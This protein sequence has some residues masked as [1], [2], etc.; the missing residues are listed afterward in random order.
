V[1]KVGDRL[2]TRTRGLTIALALLVPGIAILCL[3]ILQ[4]V[5]RAS[6]NPACVEGTHFIKSAGSLPIQV[7]FTSTQQCT[8]NLPSG[9]TRADLLVVGGGGGGGPDGGSG[10][11]GGEMRSGFATLSSP[12]VV[13]VG[14]GGLGGVWGGQGSTAGSDSTLTWSGSVQFRARGGNPGGGWNSSGPLGGSG[15][16]GGTGGS[17]QSGA[18][19]GNGPGA[20]CAPVGL[21]TRGGD[22]PT[23]SVTGGRYGGGG[24][25][26]MGVNS[27]WE[28]NRYSILGGLGG[29]GQSGWHQYNNRAYNAWHGTPNTGGGGG[30]GVACDSQ[31]T[32]GNGWWIG[33]SESSD[34]WGD[35]GPGQRTR[36]GYGGSGVVV[37]RYGAAPSI[38]TQPASKTAEHTQTTSFSLSAAVT[39]GETLSYQWQKA[40][41]TATS[42]W[43]NIS[44]ANLNTYTTGNLDRLADNG[45]LYRVVV[46][47]TLEGVTATTTSSPATLTVQDT[48]APTITNVSSTKAAGTYKAGESISI[49]VDFS[50]AVTV[51]GTPTLTLETGAVDRTVSYSSGSGTTTL[52]F[53][54]TVQAGDSTSDLNYT[55]TSALLLAGGTIRDAASNNA[56]LTLPALAGANSLAGNEALVIDTTGPTIVYSGCSGTVALGDTCTLT[57]TLSEAAIGFDSSDPTVTR[58]SLSGFAGSGLTRTVTFKALG[59]DGGTGTVT[60]ATGAFTDAVGNSNASAST[61]ITIGGVNT[62]SIINSTSATGVAVSD[63]SVGSSRYVIERFS[64]IGTTNWVAPGGVSSIEYLVVGG[65]ASG[66]RGICSVYW[67]HGGGG[68]GVSTGSLNVTGGTTYSVV[69][70]AGGAGSTTDDCLSPGVNG[71]GGSASQIKSGAT[72]LVEGSGAPSYSVNS[73]VGGSSGTGVRGGSSLQYAGG[74]GT[75]GYGAGGGGG[76]GGAGSGINGGAGVNSSI[77]GAQIM[78][79]SGGAGKNDAGFGTAQSG[80]G[81]N[82]AGT[83][84]VGGGGSDRCPTPCSAYAGSYAG[85]SGT[86]VIRY[87]LPAASTPDLADSS[88]SGSSSTDNVTSQSILTFTGSAPQSSVV[89]LQLSTNNGSTWSDTGSTCT[90]S[91]TDGS[92]SCTAATLAPGTYLFRTQTTSYISSDTVV[93]TSATSLSVTI[94]TTG[95][96]ASSFTSAQSSPTNASSLTYTLTFSESVT[97]VVSG[98]FSN[99]GS[100]TGCL[101]DPGAD[102][103]SSRTVTVTSCSQGTVIPQFAVNGATDAA[104]NTGPASAVTSSSTI[105]RDATAPSAPSALALDS[106]SDSGSSSSDRVTNNTT[107]TVNATVGET[108]GS[109]TF[110]ATGG[111]TCVVGSVASLSVSCTFT[112]LAAGVYSI[113]ATHTDSAGNVSSASSGVSITIDTTAPLVSSFS[114]AVSSP[115]SSASV[116]F[117]LSMDAA[118]SGLA[119]GDFENAGTASCSFGVSAS[120]GTS[121]TVTA[122]CTSDG[123]VQPR[124]KVASVADT[125]GNS[126]PGS[127]SS[128]S[129]TITR[130]ST[131]PSAP[132][133]PDLAIGDDSGSSGTDN[134]TSVTSP[135]V[136]V[137]AAESGG[138]TT[139]T[140]TKGASSVQCTM[141]SSTLGAS[142]SLTGLSDGTWSIAAT[143]RDAAGNT[144]STS[145]SLSVT[146]DTTAPSVSSFSSAVSS[147]TSS[148]SIAFTLSMDAAV[149]G[150]E[151]SDFENAGTATCSFGVSASSGVNFTVTATC[152][153][154]GTVE[155]YLDAATVADTAGNTGPGSVASASTTIT[156]DSTAPSAPGIPDLVAV[157][158]TGSSDSDDYTKKTSIGL[159]VT[160]SEVGGSAQIIADNGSTQRDC[161][162]T[163][164]TS[165]FTCSVTGLSHGSWTLTSRHIDEAGNV[166]T[167]SSGLTVFIDTQV[168]RPSAPTL[169]SASDTGSSNSD[170]ITNDTT[171]TVTTVVG[172]VG[173]LLIFNGGSG[174]ACSQSVTGLSVSCTFLVSWLGGGSVTATH[175]DKAGNVSAVSVTT[176]INID[177]SAPDAPSAPVLA[178]ASDSGSNS[179]DRITNVTTPSLSVTTGETGGSLTFTSS[180]GGTCTQN[181]VTSFAPTCVFGA[182]GAGTHQITAIHTDV[183]GNSSNV[184]VAT[185]IT[186]DTSAP[187]VSSFTSTSTTSNSRDVDLS[188]TFDAAVS[189]LTGGDFTNV[190]SAGVCTFAP[191]ASSGTTL[192]VSASCP[193]D[194]TLV[195]RLAAGSVADVAGNTGPAALADSSTVTIS[196]GPKSLVLITSAS[197]AAS[198]VS[199]TTQPVVELRDELNQVVTGTAATITA[200]VTQVSSTGVLVGT[201]TA[202]VDTSTGRATFSNLGLTGTAGTAY[203]LTFSSTVNSV[204]L[205][206]A[207]STVSVTQ[208]P[209]TQLAITTQPTGAGA[210]AAFAT[211]PV[212]EVRDSGGNRVTTST[213]SIGVAS[214]GGTLSGAATVSAV[215][216]IATFN[217]LNFAGTAGTNYQLTFSSSGLAPTTSSNFSVTVGAPTKIVLTT[218][219]AGA[220]YAQPF[221][222]QPVVQVQDAGSNLVASSAVV[223][224]TLGSGVVVGTTQTTLDATASG[225]TATFSGLGITGTPGSYS[226]SY[227]SPG[228]VGTSQSITV[229]QAPQSISFSD[230]A[231]AIYTAAPV[232]LSA[233]A[234]SGLT[235]SFASTT[236]LVC[237]VSGSEVTMLSS[238]TCG[239]RASQAGD[240]YFLAASPEEQAF[241]IAKAT[242]TFSW[243]NLNKTFGDDPFPVVAPT[244]S[245]AGTFVYSSADPSVVSI[246]ATTFTITGGGSTTVSATFTPTDTGKYVSGGTV[247]MTVSVARTAQAPVYL[248]STTGTYGD[249]LTLA[250]SGGSTAGSLTFDVQPGTAVGCAETGGV[251]TSLSRGTCVV[252]ATMAGSSD[253][254]SATTQ[255]TTVTLSARPI[256]VTAETKSRHYGDDDPAFTYL[257]TTGDLVNGDQLTGSLVRD[258]GD[259]VGDYSI[260][261]GTLSNDNYSIAF[262]NG[263]MSITRRPVSITADT[264]SRF[265]GDGDPLL[266]YTVTSGNLLIGETLTGTLSRAAGSDVGSYLIGRGGITNAD[267]PNYDITFVGAYFTIDRRPVTISAV[268]ASK[269]YGDSDP[270]FSHTL[271]GGSMVGSETLSGVLGRVSGTNVGTYAI[272]QGSVDNMSNGNYDVS[273]VS[274]NFTIDRRPVTISATPVSKFYGDPDPVFGWSVSGGSMAGAESLSGSLSRAVGENVGTYTITQG[275]VDN[276][277][278]GNYDVSFVSASFTI[279]RRPVTISATPVSKFYGDSDPVFAWSVSG[280]SLAGSESLSGVLGRVSGSNVGTYA[281]TQGS[282]DN[283]SNGNYD[284]SFVS[285]DLTIDRRPISIQPNVLS[286]FYGDT[287]PTLT[288]TVITGNLI[289]PDSLAGVLD[290]ATGEAVG[291]YLI[292]RGTVTNANN[293]NYNITFVGRNFTIDRRPITVTAANKEKKYSA[294]DPALTFSVTSGDLVFGDQL[295]GALTRDLGENVGDYAITQGTVDNIRNTNY[296]ITFVPG[297][298]NIFPRPITVTANPREITYGDPD[299]VFSYLIGGDGL[300]AGDSLVGA[301]A[302]VAGNN[303]GTYVITQGTLANPNYAITFYGDLLTIIRKPITVTANNL[304]ITYG[305]PNPTLTVS[306]PAGALVFGDSVLGSPVRVAGNDAGTYA[307]SQG[308][309]DNAR[310]P[311]YDITF[312]NGTL[313]IDKAPQ[314]PLVIQSTQKIFGVDLTLYHTG[315]SGDGDVTYSVINAGTANCSITGTLLSSTGNVGSSCSVQV[316]KATSL[317]Y[318]SVTSSATVT[319]IPRAITVTANSPSKTFGEND[320]PLTYTVTAGTLAVGDSLSGSLARVA[321]E[322]FGTYA[323]N[324]GTLDNSN[325][326][327]TFVPGTFTINKRPITVTADSAEK[328]AGASDPPSFTY[329]VTSGS[330]ANAGDLTGALGRGAGELIGSYAISQGTLNNPNYN[331]TFNPGTFTIRGVSQSAMTLTATTNPIVFQDQTD[332]S[333]TGGT[334]NGEL[335]FS[336][337]SS[338][339]VGACSITPVSG[340]AMATVVGLKAGTCTLI[341]DKASDGT[342]EAAQ[343]NV[344]TITI[345]KK[346]QAI[347]FNSPG[348]QSYSETPFTVSPSSDSG[349]SVG[350]VSTTTSICSVSGFQVLTLF[351][352]LCELV[353]SIA[354]SDN[355]LAATPVPVQFN[356][357]AVAP[358]APTIS[359]LTATDD[360]IAVTFTAGSHGGE[361]IDGYEYSLDGGT[362]WVAFPAGSITSPLVINGLE[363]STAYEVRLRS[364]TTVSASPASNPMSVTTPAA[365]VASQTPGGGAVV[366]STVVTTTPSST[367]VVTTTVVTTTAPS[368]TGPSTSTA[369]TVVTT[370]V[371]QTSTSSPAVSTVTSQRV[372]SS[373]AQ[374]NDGSSTP[375]SSGSGSSGSSGSGGSA[376]SQQSAQS[377]A[378]VSVSEMSPGTSAMTRDGEPT[379]IAWAPNPDGGVVA[380]W[381]DVEIQIMASS[382]GAQQ[383]LMPDGTF[384]VETGK[385]IEFEA[386]GLAPSSSVDAW[387]FSEPTFLGTATADVDGKV[388]AEF[389]VPESVEIGGHTLKLQVIESDGTETEIAVGIVVFDAE[390]AAMNRAG[391]LDETATALLAAPTTV[392]AVS[393]SSDHSALV[394]VWLILLLILFVAVG[395]V[396]QIRYRRR[397]PDAVSVLIDDAEWAHRLGLAR[398]LLPIAGFVLGAWASS[399]TQATPVTPSA[400]LMLILLVVSLLDPFAAAA[401]TFAF[402]T[403]VVVGGGVESADGLRA[404]IVVAAMWV[405]PGLLGSTVSRITSSRVVLIP[406]AVRAAVSTSMF[407]ALVEV[408]PVYTRVETTT[409]EFVTEF[410]W[411]VAIVSMLR[412]LL[413]SVAAGEGFDERRIPRRSA[414]AS[415]VCLGVVAFM[416]LTDRTV[417]TST[418]VGFVALGAVMSLRWAIHHRDRWASYATGALASLVALAIGLSAI[419]WGPTSEPTETVS[420]DAELVSEGDSTLNSVTVYVDSYPEEFRAVVTADHRI[421]VGHDDFGVEMTVASRLDSGVVVPVQGGRP[422]LVVGQTVTLT[423]AGLAARSPIETWIYSVPRQ[424]GVKE[425]TPQGRVDAEFEV[426]ADQLPGPHDLRIRVVL[427]NGRSALISIPVDVVVAVPELT[428]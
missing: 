340:S 181:P 209:A 255:P 63:G 282:V 257:V 286:K 285:A 83:N 267:N 16:S 199:F 12:V 24:G 88:D 230:P 336:I 25:G 367:T 388:A 167:S 224:A 129:T 116:A 338:N 157:D 46:T 323:I 201:V 288:Y 66:T 316:T 343:S 188:L 84:G 152:S 133:T 396:G 56:T 289:S 371:R 17:G 203:T 354:Q 156:R 331:I 106:S 68:G 48:T 357:N 292:G 148:A 44:G 96:S 270:T 73:A 347:T 222:T 424:L 397:T 135:S 412:A 274:A 124:L 243:S 248:S 426:P 168:A 109:V 294:A 290:R 59:V 245:V 219:A 99:T 295:A 296:D 346:A 169:D 190:G 419:S 309:V 300:K 30:A 418:V 60:V 287:D 360:W 98:D 311:N 6:A 395:R 250:V 34:G 47:S 373:V 159:S 94:D 26:G 31:S 318:L 107:P 180:L 105:T 253:Y 233:T 91:S 117:T 241:E 405:L 101:F 19:G 206:A 383:P 342:Y 72:V 33:G 11:G 160:V 422:Q 237:S 284:V 275:S 242:P 235:V 53:S 262:V 93:Q 7:T 141:V 55:S 161:S 273:F 401:A 185:D 423:G 328:Y 379:E 398:W 333:V 52:N 265:Y 244:A 193:Q 314:T 143:D 128:A 197:G 402:V 13:A 111:S 147:L 326:T 177:T 263:T 4:S 61:N 205:T 115:T 108:G 196:T 334:G 2:R 413:D 8:W 400:L 332:V 393:M 341:A 194:G 291:S 92:W 229:Q 75:G 351:A 298:L 14:S 162:G 327:I 155:P 394:V 173:G 258:A 36:G 313:T 130:D 138:T 365:P 325:Y 387:L 254:F 170:R 131:A 283:M 252:T 366:E 348:D 293:P 28:G 391:E 62:R 231:D 226:I 49:Q 218:T 40:E 319:V 399:S 78:Y 374:S 104:G 225:G 187:S 390:A 139:V 417:S 212:I 65:G 375:A 81:S 149:S 299:P 200:N 408:L 54:Y 137:V 350:L 339:P 308:T 407:V 362:T 414:W 281:I 302:R 146:I 80:G 183:A 382:G 171:P 261:R 195:A 221:T 307:I 198:G 41:S 304:T 315:G 163:P 385:V 364:L 345:N 58:G 114:S 178:T 172:E 312:V 207:T 272:T 372:T 174:S 71:R 126:G 191:S 247:T 112:T 330:L 428:I 378:P 110:T 335:N 95:P 403:G 97:G 123:T 189:G 210:G 151:G 21:G 18:S 166:S 337:V 85:G 32:S 77:T 64:A 90:S 20:S 67:G 211:A 234:S 381:N 271:T 240:T 268:P 370:T 384:G 192:T 121:F 165:T 320:P 39:Y 278:N 214:S 329:Q 223:T 122:T 322:T 140:A 42:N 369:T 279:D 356:V 227:S 246:S 87:A 76:A 232:T 202:S 22:G 389:V 297:N 217:N 427:S 349:L 425:T 10:G 410:A 415:F 404:L 352:G 9:V 69:V 153:T 134:V 377:S 392:R 353:G 344:L 409:N 280:G 176:F 303:V 118:V 321:G 186:I 306:T 277:S 215:A 100:A 264:L 317:N 15:G 50:E 376:N 204:V 184:S 127:A 411:V 29:G 5:N 301:L 150:L 74:T 266:T 142:C 359:A 421:V 27:R 386:D 35:T 120:S 355:Y 236:P 86:V 310:N 251:L 259:V 220:V 216:G 363:R 238:G 119:G 175:T 182:L 260:R 51:T 380:A 89:Q 269:F 361:S 256:I 305:D 158:D 416:T 368:T 406:A 113:T 154:D 420:S 45:D 1:G 43:S 276:T 213:A 57:L 145:T 3:I 144:S 37:F 38:Q 82:S 239:L 23:W 324:Q 102:S 136:S 179:S 208:G 358:S 103:G 132:G 164:A 79:G 249:A 125:A 70:G 228:L